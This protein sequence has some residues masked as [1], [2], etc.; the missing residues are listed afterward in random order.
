MPHTAAGCYIL[1]RCSIVWH[2]AAVCS[3]IALYSVVQHSFPGCS[4]K[5]S[6][7]QCSSVYCEVT[8]R[9]TVVLCIL[10]QCGTVVLC[11]VVQ[12]GTVVLRAAGDRAPGLRLRLPADS[13]TEATEAGAGTW[14]R[15]SRGLA[16]GCRH[17]EEAGRGDRDPAQAPDSVEL[18]L[19]PGGRD[20]WR[21]KPQIEL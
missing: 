14:P 1:V 21:G 5:Y 9:G 17:E 13:T 10:V 12:C 20:E 6:A 2:G 4:S 8:Q 18:P 3:S 11:I 7:A 16:A 15:R 19:E